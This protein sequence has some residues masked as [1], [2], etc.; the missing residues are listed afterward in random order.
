MVEVI[1][2]VV[3]SY[4]GFLTLE[5][6][7]ITL[8]TAIDITTNGNLV[9]SFCYGC[10]NACGLLGTDVDCCISKHISQFTTTID[11]TIDMGTIDCLNLVRS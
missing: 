11:I 7:I 5:R 8:S 1:S 4:H 6:S 9:G 2:M 3:R 10:V